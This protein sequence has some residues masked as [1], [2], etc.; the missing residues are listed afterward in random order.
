MM[1][2]SKRKYRVIFTEIDKG[3]NVLASSKIKARQAA[4]NKLKIDPLHY[5]ATEIIEIQD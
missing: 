4:I 5:W 3:T 2:K 1:S